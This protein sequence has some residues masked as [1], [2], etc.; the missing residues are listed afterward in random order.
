V[1]LLIL[2]ITAALI[3]ISLIAVSNVLVFPRLRA[4]EPSTDAPFVSVMIPARNEAAVIGR[5]ITHL[6]T[7]DYPNYE[8]ILLD[9]N[10]DDDTAALARTAAEDSDKLTIID[11]QPLPA[12]WM[13]KNW[14]CQQMQQVARGDLLIF[15]DADVIWEGGAVGALSDAM[16]RT[17]ADLYTIWPTQHTK[18]WAER[19]CVSLMAVVVV[20][21]LPLI[22]T[23]YVPLSVFGAANG[24]CMAWRRDAYDEIGGHAA[25]SDNVLEDVTLARMVKGAGMRLRMADGNHLIRCRMYN[26]WQSVRNGYAKNI[27]A[28][29]GSVPALVI[30]TIFHWLIFL[31]PWLWLAVGW[32]TPGLPGYPLWP[33]LLIVLGLGIRALTAAF[34]HQRVRDAL[35]MPVSV[36][37]MTR[38]AFQAIWWHYTQGG[39]TWKGRIVRKQ[40]TR[41]RTHG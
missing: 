33:L 23:H 14:A 26:D 30:A 6:L 39:P 9:D 20:G 41:N 13:G 25:I 27:L 35:L 10:S 31:F 7:Q 28:G 15:T 1:L 37:L 29:Y 16:Q 4:S 22:G 3:V 32:A 17:N 19:L 34:T 40:P 2:F 8:V 38:I 11:G 18:T 5:T 36:V 12:G 21:Y 24:Q